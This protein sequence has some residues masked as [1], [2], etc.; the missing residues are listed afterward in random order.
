[1][2]TIKKINHIGIAVEDMQAALPFWQEVM[3]IQLDHQEEN[4]D[5]T[6]QIAF[7]PVGESDLEL[8]APITPESGMAKFLS[9]HGGGGGGRGGGGI[10]HICFE[11]DDIVGML[12]N[13]KAAGVRLINE[14][15]Q[16]MEGRLMAFVHPKSTG[17]ILI[18]F[19]ELTK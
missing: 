1:M 13:L 3:G 15:P 12:A 19:Y 14:T 18:E 17:G 5:H 6:S 7:L 11:V 8:V 10:H 16:Q 9:E 2:A 4:L